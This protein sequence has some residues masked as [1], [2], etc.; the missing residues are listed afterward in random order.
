[1]GSDLGIPEVKGDSEEEE[2]RES[3]VLGLQLAVSL[4]SLCSVG[5]QIVKKEEV[6]CV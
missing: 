3:L 4:C 6:C 2:L 5:Q 1:M